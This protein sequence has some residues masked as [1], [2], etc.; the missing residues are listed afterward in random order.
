MSGLL[1]SQFCARH[2]I[3][4]DI[5]ILLQHIQLHNTYIAYMI[6]ITSDIRKRRQ[7]LIA[8]L[9][10]VFHNIFAEIR[11]LANASEYFTE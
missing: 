4:R 3:R 9:S 6:N 7:L 11:Q 10:T 1:S 8:G 5:F 2:P